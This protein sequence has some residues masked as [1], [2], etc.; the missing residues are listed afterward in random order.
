M[1]LTCPLGR[2]L[3]KV[4]QTE[5][6]INTPGRFSGICS[7]PLLFGY[8]GSFLFL[9]CIWVL[10]SCF[11][12]DFFNYMHL[13]ILDNTWVL[14]SEYLILPSKCFTFLWK[15]VLIDWSAVPHFLSYKCDMFCNT[16]VSM[17]HFS[18]TFHRLHHFSQWLR[19]R[20]HCQI[21]TPYSTWM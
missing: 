3:C 14:M 16:D 6:K 11:L 10:L 2:S 17:F 15:N 19:I 5:N 7:S 8:F 20:A 1:Y 9:L 12:Y 4:D 18:I 21:C 13:D